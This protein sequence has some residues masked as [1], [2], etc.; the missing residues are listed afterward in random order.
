MISSSPS[1]G[2][3]VVIGTTVEVTI[4]PRQPVH[5]PRHHRTHPAQARTTLSAA[6]YQGGRLEIT[7]R[8]VPLTS[9]DDGKILSQSPAAGTHRQERPGVGRRGPRKSVAELGRPRPGSLTG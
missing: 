8:N 1:A 7:Y 9:R 3:T 5:G 6:G 2:T 4:S